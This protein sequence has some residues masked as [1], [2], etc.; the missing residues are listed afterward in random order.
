MRMDREEDPRLYG[1]TVY[2]IDD[3]AGVL[4]NADGKVTEALATPNNVT[5]AVLTRNR[6]KYLKE[7]LGSIEESLPDGTI[8]YVLPESVTHV[9]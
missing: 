4:Y 1:G 6:S 3:S 7:L 9:A 8:R 2:R 5:V